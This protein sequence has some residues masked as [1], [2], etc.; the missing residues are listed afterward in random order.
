MRGGL[1]DLVMLRDKSRRRD[2]FESLNEIPSLDPEADYSSME[3]KFVEVKGP[4]DRLA[5]R[6]EVWMQILMNAGVSCMVCHV[7]ET[8]PKKRK[9]AL[10]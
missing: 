6:Q 9:I 4:R 8:E 1:P 7:V 10:P 2:F 5:M 3:I